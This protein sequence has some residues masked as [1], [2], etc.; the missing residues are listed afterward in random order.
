MRAHIDTGLL[1]SK[2]VTMKIYIL[3]AALF[4]LAACGSTPPENAAGNIVDVASNDMVDDDVTEVADDSATV[5][6]SEGAPPPAA[7]MT[8]SEM[9]DEAI[10]KK[11][12]GEE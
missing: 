3:G 9:E 6:E 4:A 8:Q 2:L 11:D 5:S 1:M 7:P 12:R 10:A